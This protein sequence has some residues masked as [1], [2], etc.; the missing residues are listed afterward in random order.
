MV[1]ELES[2]LRDDS[3]DSLLSRRI[4]HYNVELHQPCLPLQTII[5]LFVSSSFNSDIIEYIYI[6]SLLPYCMVWPIYLGLV[7]YEKHHQQAMTVYYLWSFLMNIRTSLK[8]VGYVIMWLDC[9][10][11]LLRFLLLVMYT[12]AFCRSLV[13]FL[14]DCNSNGASISFYVI[15]NISITRFRPLGDS[16]RC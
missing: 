5:S 14:R 2:N 6:E 10:G 7:S 9:F 11:T 13:A 12:K 8:I 3:T 1:L 16:W 4:N 15:Y